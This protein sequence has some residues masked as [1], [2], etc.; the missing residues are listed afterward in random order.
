[1][2]QFQL[3]EYLKLREYLQLLQRSTA[4]QASARS[5]KKVPTKKSPTPKNKSATKRISTTKKNTSKKSPPEK[6]LSSKLLT[7]PKK[8]PP[9]RTTKRPQPL[10]PI[11]D[12]VQ[13]ISLNIQLPLTSDNP[14]SISPNKS[15][16][17]TVDEVSQNANNSAS[18]TK[19]N[20]SQTPPP[21]RSS[22][23]KGALK[24]GAAQ[25][26]GNRLNKTTT[27]QSTQSTSEIPPIIPSDA[28]EFPELIPE[29]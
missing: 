21:R 24:S 15:E 18:P 20:R 25:G 19:I 5:L 9:P 23:S 29:V 27:R 6:L 3:R 10:E 12:K 2:N 8:P 28:K 4:S 14:Q 13:E 17:G 16:S 11:T 22:Q 1:M 7:V 26:L